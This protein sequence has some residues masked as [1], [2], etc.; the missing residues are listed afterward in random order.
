M[1][2]T[3]SF[4]FCILTLLL[5]A[6][7]T[8]SPKV[9][10]QPK[11]TES[12]ITIR[13]PLRHDG[14]MNAF[15]FKSGV[16]IRTDSQVMLE[17]FFRYMPQQIVS[18]DQVVLV[19]NTDSLGAESYNLKLSLERAE[20]IKSIFIENG[21]PTE[22]IVIMGKGSEMWVQNPAQCHGSLKQRQDC[23]RVNRRVDYDFIG[24]KVKEGPLNPLMH[25]LDMDGA[26]E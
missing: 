1:M 11:P 5:S 9:L 7:S 3:H 26:H 25:A 4:V 21:F 15:Y 14:G 19:G 10:S 24:L 17:R 13:N 20:K 2:K 12:K 16:Q 18:F 6:C 22:K 8:P 23:E